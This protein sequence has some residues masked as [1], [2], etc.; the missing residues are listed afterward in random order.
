M[1]NKNQTLENPNTIQCLPDPERIVEGL[2]DT[3]YTFNTAIADI[4]DNAVTAD[5]SNIDIRIDLN[6]QNEVTVYIADNGY[7]MN[8]EGLEN[9]MTY[10]SKKR[11]DLK[12]LGKFGLGLKTASTAFCRSLSVITRGREDSTVRKA[13]WDLDYIAQE[14]AWLLKKPEVDRDEL[15]MLEITTKGEAG[16]LV[17]W[18]KIDRLFRVNY[19]RSGNA[20]AALKKMIDDLEFHLSMVYQRFLDKNDERAN[21]VSITVNG[22]D[23][24]PWDPFVV[25]EEYT[26]ILAEEDVEATLPDETKSSFRM[27]AFL[28]PNKDSFSTS[29]ASKDARISNDRQGFYVYRENRLIHYGDWLGMFINEPHGSLLR[30]EFSFDHLL[31]EA[32]NVDIKKSRILPAEEIM[33]FIKTSFIPAPRRAASERYRRGVTKNVEKQAE[34]QDAH[35]GS[36]RNIEEKASSVEGAKIT[37]T[38]TDEV[39]IENKNGVFSHKISIVASPKPGQVRIIPKADLEHNQLWMPCIVDSKHAVAINQSHP[40]YQKVYAPILAQNVMV[41]GMDALL[42]ALAESEH[43]TYNEEVKELYEDIRIA[44]SKTLKTL[45]E[46]LPDPEEESDEE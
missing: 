37:V 26:E 4:I 22:K 33:D 6:P 12:S 20:R 2:R 38:D 19:I 45:V 32:F 29:K 28:L 11:E 43:M 8:E 39:T 46:D 5:A 18:R 10:G 3:G 9:A 24:E 27:R 31:D 23:I 16:T 1:S 25:T 34:K 21:N 7:G 42:W 13:E 17:V 41:T 15:E 14:H 40:Y 44:V 30:V 36:N 35:A